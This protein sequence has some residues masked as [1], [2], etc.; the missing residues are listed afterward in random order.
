MDKPPLWTFRGYTT[1]AGNSLVQEWFYEELGIEE[2]DSIRDR[3]NYLKDIERHLWIRPSFDKLEDDLSEIRIKTRAGPIRMY[4]YFPSGE[5]HCF[6]ILLGLYKS[7]DNDRKGKNIAKDRLRL[8]R[9]EKGNTHEFSFEER[10]SSENSKGKENQGTIG[11]F[12]L[13]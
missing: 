8:L 6:V 7:A 1:E 12:K 5:R 10:V 9:Q 3:I 4:G 13:V 2:R 11:R